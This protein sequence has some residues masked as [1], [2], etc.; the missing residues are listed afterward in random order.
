MLDKEK[1][2]KHQKP[3]NV[4]FVPHLYTVHYP[5][6]KDDSLEKTFSVIENEISTILDNLLINQKSISQLELQKLLEFT[7]IMML[8]SPMVVNIAKEECVSNKTIAQLRQTAKE[9]AFLEETAEQYIKE[10]SECDG[11]AFQETFF[12]LFKERALKIFTHF[13][14][15]IIK[16]PDRHTFAIGDRY[17]TLLTTDEFLQNIETYKKN[18]GM[19]W[20]HMPVEIICPISAEYAIAYTKKEEVSKKLDITLKP[21]TIS[22]E[23]ITIINKNTVQQSDRYTY[24]Q[25]GQPLNND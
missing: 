13:N 9:K 5:D 8:R 3:E 12:P 20:W 6:K 23:L 11:L 7:I 16:A 19:D 15:R 18:Y 22:K 4:G 17:F 10:M 25:E 21:Q 1:G 14:A 2:I 24:A